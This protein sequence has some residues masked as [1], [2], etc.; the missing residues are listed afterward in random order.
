MTDLPG[1]AAAATGGRPLPWFGRLALSAGL[2][3]LGVLRSRLGFARLGAGRRLVTRRLGRLGVV[4][5]RRVV[6]GR[7]IFRRPIFGRR[8]VRFLG[9]FFLRRFF[10]GRRLR[11][12]ASLLFRL[13]VGLFQLLG[14]LARAIGDLGLFLGE[15]LGLGPSLGLAAHASAA[16]RC[17]RLSS[18]MVSTIRCVSVFRRSDR[19]SLNRSCSN[20]CRSF[21]AISCPS[22]ARLY[23]FCASNATIE[24]SW[25]WVRR[26]LDC[27]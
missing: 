20:S 21:C 15:L 3:G 9:R 27:L 18:L 10:V 24:L 16:D 2:R 6:G 25:D 26:S 23:C 13:S 8:F 1:A 19:S 14:Q 5:C 11:F 12:R 7:P 17:R 4:G 22:R